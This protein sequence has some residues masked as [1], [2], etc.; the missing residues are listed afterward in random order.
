VFLPNPQNLSVDFNWVLPEG[1]IDAKGNAITEYH[2]SDPG[3]LKFKNIGSQKIVLKTTLGG[4]SLEEGVVN[5]QVGYNAPA[6][7]IYYAVKGGNLMAMK[8]IPNVPAGMKNNSFDLGIKSGQHPMNLLFSD[9]CLY[10]V[11]AGKQF[12]YINDADG[13]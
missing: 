4:R 9:S 10:V 11:D 5:V 6:K 2:G 8:L 7:T 1:T 13:V 12:T 3:Q